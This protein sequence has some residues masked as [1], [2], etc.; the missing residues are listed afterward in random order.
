MMIPK[1]YVISHKLNSFLLSKQYIKHSGILQ[2]FFNERC[3]TQENRCHATTFHKK[4]STWEPA[5]EPTSPLGELPDFSKLVQAMSHKSTLDLFRTYVVLR[6]CASDMI[7]DNSQSLLKL[8]YNVLGHSLTNW[9]VKRTFFKQFCASENE[10]GLLP[11]MQT[12]ESC[13]ISGILDYAAEADVNDDEG[14]IKEN[15]IEI[16]EG[17]DNETDI[18]RT[19]PYEGEVQCDNATEVFI[20]CIETAYQVSQHSLTGSHPFAAIKVTALGNPSLLKRMSEMIHETELLFDR[21]ESSLNKENPDGSFTLEEWRKAFDIFFNTPDDDPNVAER[22]FWNAIGNDKNKDKIDAVDWA[23]SMNIKVVSHLVNSCKEKGPLFKVTLTNEELR[24]AKALFGRLDKLASLAYSKGVSLMIDAE[25]TYFQPC[26]EANIIRLQRLYNKTN[27]GTP[28]VFGTYQCYLKRTNK[29]LKQDLERSKR[30]GWV[31][32]AKLVRGAYMVSERELALEKGYPSPI[33]D[34]I[35][36]THK[37]YDQNV[38]SL[39]KDPHA[40][41]MIASHNQ[42]SCYKACELMVENNMDKKKGGVYFG[43][44]LG[45]SDHI[46]FSL[47]LHGYNAFKYLPYGQVEEVLPYLIRRAQENSG[48]M[49]GAI[50]ERKIILNEIKRR[51]FNSKEN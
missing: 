27:D 39:I 23:R 10:A 47:G 5:R 20:K 41:V 26:I 34:S 9:L 15:T 50:Y 35:E 38:E 17:I 12:L 43:Q 13:G 22:L 11:I 8:S 4:F 30:E 1:N 24:L 19:Y 29:Q 16:I 21:M 40:H 37:C 31:L 45:M 42:D 36:E 51:L 33:H 48:L 25:Q 46:T 18:A 3:F 14:T 7:V 49:S 28:T 44:L 2:T 32:A 6:V